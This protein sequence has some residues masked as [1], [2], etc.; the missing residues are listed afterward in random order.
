MKIN[1]LIN[2][3]KKNLNNIQIDYYVYNRNHQVY[4]YYDKYFSIFDTYKIAEIKFEYFSNF[5]QIYFY[6]KGD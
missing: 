6:L 1:E 5:T 2:Y 4:F 3:F